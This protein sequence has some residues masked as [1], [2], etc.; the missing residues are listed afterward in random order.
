VRY[1]RHGGPEV[2][3]VEHLLDPVAADDGVLVRVRAAGL[4][5]GELAIRE[6]RLHGPAGRRSSHEHLA[7]HRARGKLVLQISTVGAP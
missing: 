6:G 3:E 2:R 5:P 4:N 7:G 1:D